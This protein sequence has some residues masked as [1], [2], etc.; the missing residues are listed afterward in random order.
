MTTKKREPRF[1]VEYMGETIWRNTKPGS[2]LK[3]SCLGYGAADTLAGMKE[4]IRE[5]RN[6]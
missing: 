6:Q 5:G 1:I 3:W 2:Y 4:L